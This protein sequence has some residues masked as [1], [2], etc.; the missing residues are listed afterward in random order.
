[1]MTDISKIRIFF[2]AQLWTNPEKKK[3]AIFLPLSV[4]M[5]LSTT[6]MILY[7]LNTEAFP[8]SEKNVLF[9]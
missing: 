9:L 7:F 6:A 4:N 1:M 8:F 2:K 3:I 5:K